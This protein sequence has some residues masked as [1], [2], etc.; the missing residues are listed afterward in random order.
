MSGTSPNLSI[1]TCWSSGRHT[2]GCAMLEE[3]A[4][5]GFISVELGH[6]TR[7]SLWPGI[8][9]AHEQKIIR[10]DS[11]HNFCPL[12]MGFLKPSPN[13]FEFSDPSPTL[14]KKAVRHSRE[15][16]EHAA[17]LGAKAVVLHMGSLPLKNPNRTFE[18]LVGEGRIGS[19]RYVRSKLA[20][21]TEHERL[22]QERWPWVRECLY[23]LGELATLK[24]IRLGLECRESVEEI[25]LESQWPAI[26]S[27][28]PGVFGYWH[29]FGHAA[30]KDALA[31]T[32][33]LAEFKKNAPRLLGCHIHD[34]TPPRHDHR[35][36]GDGDIDF[37]PFWPLL[38]TQPS[39]V[40]ELSPSVTTD[41]VESCLKWWK[42]NGPK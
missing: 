32:N 23:E 41:K 38:Q 34:F 15:T 3:L 40:L 5:L 22:F 42:T 26:F 35:A 30:R 2:D 10:I 1:S 4:E 33:H 9:R 6:G 29:D 14:R 19:R 31:F 36:P 8:L 11:L 24:N 12:P 20:A 27:E 18:K 28:M 37:A 16:I 13:C 21:L 7:Y 39:F 25:P 17:F